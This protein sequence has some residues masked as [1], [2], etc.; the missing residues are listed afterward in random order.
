MSR[1]LALVADL[2]LAVQEEIRRGQIG[3][4]AAM[5]YLVPLARVD[6]E[7]CERLAAGIAGKELSDR[8]IGM[9]YTAWREAPRSTRNRLLEDPLLLVRALHE[10]S[11]RPP[12]GHPG[13]IL[14]RDAERLVA[15]S[16]RACK[17]WPEAVGELSP[18]QREELRDRLAQARADL[19]QLERILIPKSLGISDPAQNNSAVE[20]LDPVP[21]P[22]GHNRRK[23][24]RNEHAQSKPTS[25][26]SR[27]A[28]QRLQDPSDRADASHLSEHSDAGGGVEVYT[29]VAG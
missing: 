26:D 4:Q 5:R 20:P 18:S 21:S 9:L 14:L 22:T 6:R 7:A 28:Q 15:S 25:G 8:E 23:E 29:H 12:P 27:D 16:R 24:T 10:V 3:A 19:E 13:E 1:R 2:P 17:E 11:R